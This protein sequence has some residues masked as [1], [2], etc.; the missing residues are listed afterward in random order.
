ML[1]RG[2]ACDSLLRLFEAWEADP[3]IGPSDSLA[4][5]NTVLL[6]GMQPKQKMRHSIEYSKKK[7][8]GLCLMY[9]YLLFQ[10]ISS[11]NGENFIYLLSSWIAKHFLLVFP[12]SLNRHIMVIY[13]LSFRTFCAR[14]VKRQAS[15]LCVLTYLCLPWN[16]SFSWWSWGHQKSLRDSLNRIP[17]NTSMFLFFLVGIIFS[18]SWS[19]VFSLYLED[20]ST[21]STCVPLFRLCRSRP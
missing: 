9:I 16:S 21:I 11:S 2:G 14:G 5:L 7:K 20:S 17:A 3:G 8:K 18:F 1:H 13:G 15:S 12:K 6:L 10:D 4:S 19:L